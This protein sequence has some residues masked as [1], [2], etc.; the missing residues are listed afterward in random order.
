MSPLPTQMGSL[1]KLDTPPQDLIDAA[2]IVRQ[3]TVGS[4]GLCPAR[5][6][7]AWAGLVPPAISEPLVFGTTVHDLIEQHLLNGRADIKSSSFDEL[8]DSILRDKYEQ[9]EGIEFIPKKD[10]K[11]F[12]DEAINA[13]QLWVFQVYEHSVRAELKGNKRFYAEQDLYKNLGISRFN[14]VPILG[15]GTPD[16]VTT[17]SFWDW[18][19]TNGAFK[20]NQQKADTEFQAT[21]YLALHNDQGYRDWYLDTFKFAVFDR[22]KSD[23]NVLSTTRTQEQ[24]DAAFTLAMAYGEQIDSGVFPATPFV[25]NYGKMQQGWYCSPKYCG[26]WDVCEFKG[27]GLKDSTQEVEVTWP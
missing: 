23:W 25:E 4:F 6:G 18:K 11:R 9:N 14:G 21:Y 8:L 26:A 16:L 22:K 27:I 10:Y 13:Y 15:R 24:M 3:S 19:T 2:I 12:K 20:W 5:V 7:Y 17:H 1:V